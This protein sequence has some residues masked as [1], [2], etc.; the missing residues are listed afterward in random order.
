RGRLGAGAPPSLVRRTAAPLGAAA[1]GGKAAPADRHITTEVL[2]VQQDIASARVFT[3]QFNDYLQLVKRNGAWQI[4]NVLW[5]APPAA[6]QKN[7][8]ATEGVER[9]VR[10]SV[11]ALYTADGAAL[12]AVDDTHAHPCHHA[13]RPT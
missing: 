12:L 4:L 1:K 10:A 2:D 11:T 5:H 13:P 7:E 3:A 9:A 6:G 8:G